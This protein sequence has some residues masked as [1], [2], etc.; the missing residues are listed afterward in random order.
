MHPAEIIA[1]KRDGGSHSTEEIAA[2]IRGFTSGEV[3]DY[4]MSAWTM[5]VYLRGLNVEETL[6]LTEAMLR[7]GEVLSSDGSGV[8]VDKHSTGGMGD[9]SSFIVA[10]LLA[11]CGL[12]VPMISGRGLGA[13][14]GTLDKLE[15]IPGVRTD[16][17]TD[18]IRSV[19]ER[20]GCVI[21]G[22]TATL[23]PA[24][25]R[26]YA[27][28]D[29]TATVSSIPLITAS[30]LSK[31]L[32]E[33]LTALVLDV[34]YGSGAFMKTRDQARLLARSLVETGSRLGL[35][36]T[37]LVT[38][39]NQPNGRMV[40]GSVEIDESLETLAGAGP[41]DLRELSLELAAEVLV[42]TSLAADIAAARATLTAH[43][44]SGR[45]LEKFREMVTAQGGDLDAPRRRAPTWTLESREAG[46]VAAMD[47]E[48]LGLA[49][50]E[51]GGGRKHLGEPIDHGVGIEMLVR[52]GDRV[53]RGQPLMNILAPTAARSRG[54]RLLETCI[55]LAPVA[56]AREPL[57]AERIVS[58]GTRHA[59]GMQGLIDQALAV[60]DHAHAPYSGFR[61]G[62]ALLATSGRVYLGANVENASYGLTQCAERVAFTAAVAAGETQFER[63]VIASEGGAAPCGACRQVAAE[64]CRE[65]PIMLVDNVTGQVSECRLSELLP[66]RFE[67]A[68][69]KSDQDS[70]DASGHEAGQRSTEHRP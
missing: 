66:A 50:V 56:A 52:L 28:R 5:A 2:L 37:A 6:A 65:L 30:I 63:L 42:M 45:A 21:T 34:K 16:L 17:S 15:S 59:A 35:R 33:S 57:I 39:M 68:R 32:A 60:R 13:T 10:P 64:F 40:G 58:G 1:H 27:L 49:V 70:G 31:K 61:V 67:F 20:V 54:L 53:E 51:M 62:A 9:K 48:R 25:R 41:A 38:P 18:E 12:K 36:T 69:R 47:A 19:V 8:R 24:D 29:V 43:L 23:V 4:Q 7:S 3:H 26:L 46:Y 14:G 44:D 11:C 55:T 22:A